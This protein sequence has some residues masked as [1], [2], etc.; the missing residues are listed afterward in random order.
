[1]TKWYYFGLGIKTCL[2]SVILF[3][4]LFGEV[5]L[6]PMKKPLKAY[7]VLYPIVVLFVVC[8][9]F[10]TVRQMWRQ[11][12]MKLTEPQKNC[13]YCHGEKDVINT[14]HKDSLNRELGQIVHIERTYLVV[15]ENTVESKKIN[16]CPMCGRL[17]NKEDNDEG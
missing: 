12:R 4:L 11:G 8:C 6:G 17:L 16:Y 10:F 3:L 13:S 5:T 9:L 14:L 15:E 7:S 2:L 1:M